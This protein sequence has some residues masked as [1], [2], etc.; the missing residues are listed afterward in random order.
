MFSADSK[1]V[2]YAVRKGDQWLVV[3]DGQAGPEYGKIMCGPVFRPDGAVEYLAAKTEEGRQ[4]L[5]RV[6]HSL[7]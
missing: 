3:V 1:R 2:A 6:N 7:P 4:V 5:Y